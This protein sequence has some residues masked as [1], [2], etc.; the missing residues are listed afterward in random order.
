PAPAAWADGAAWPPAG[1]E[2]VE[3]EDV[4]AHFSDLGYEYGEAFAGIGSVWR[5]PG[6]VFAEVRLPARVRADAADY[7][8][9]PA[10]LD[11]ALQPWLAGGLLDV[12]DGS[13][14]L[15][16]AWQGATL[17]AAGADALRVRIARA[18]EGAVCLEAVDPAGAPVL[19]LDALV[20]RPVAR[21][22]LDAL[23]GAADSALPLYR[24][25]WRDTAA[26]A[27]G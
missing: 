18:G 22:R 24:I 2:R 5:R 21:E 12:P 16:F 27:T 13:V 26:P 8:L 17:H 10:L 4:Y 20:M 23:L 7:G 14:L 15:P 1:A 19:T 3:A 9:H 25:D 11:A 6:E